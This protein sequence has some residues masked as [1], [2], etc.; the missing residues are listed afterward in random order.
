MTKSGCVEILMNLYARMGPR[1]CLTPA[2]R[3][4]FFKAAENAEGEIRRFCATLAYTGCR[5]SEALALT[6]DRAD[7]KDGTLI[8]ESLKKRKRG[9]F[10]PIPVPPGFLDTLNM[11]HDIRTAPRRRDR[12]KGVHL[13]SWCRATAWTRVGEVVDAAGINGPHATPRGLRHG[14]GIK[15]VTSN[16]P[17]NMVKTWLGHA[18]LS[19]PAIHADAMGPEAKQIE[20]MRQ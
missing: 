4:E 15:A 6:P 14:F 12:G 16:V 17:L 13:W 1:K 7:L 18:Q 19:T 9:V 8:F 3:D 11:V 20:R 10:R 5:I 2:E